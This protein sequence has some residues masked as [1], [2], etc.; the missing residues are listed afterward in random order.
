MQRYLYLNEWSR[1]VLLGKPTRLT[2]ALSCG[3]GI[4]LECGA[5]S[6]W[7]IHLPRPLENDS[8]I[9]GLDIV[10]LPVWTV[11]G[12]V[13]CLLPS[14]KLIKMMCF[15][16]AFQAFDPPQPLL[17]AHFRLCD[18]WCWQIPLPR[19]EFQGLKTTLQKP[20]RGCHSC[21]VHWVFCQWPRH[22]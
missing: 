18:L 3:T 1:R 20:I 19:R 8:I 17:F 16:G 10:C 15:I 6:R 4:G 7:V 11:G 9:Q 13:R 22:C 21:F 5:G 14:V 2:V 12:E